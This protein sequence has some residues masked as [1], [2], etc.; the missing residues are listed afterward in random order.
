MSLNVF[1][2][3]NYPKQYGYFIGLK[4]NLILPFK[5]IF[6]FL[7]FDIFF[8]SKDQDKWVVREIF[9]NKKNGFFVDLAAT[10][11]FHQNN[12]YFLEK[13]LNWRGVCI[14]PNKNFFKKLIKLRNVK[15][16]C[17]IVS[18]KIENVNYLNNGGVGGIIGDKFDN[19]NKKRKDLIQ[20]ALKNNRVENRQSKTLYEILKKAKAPKVIDYLS[21][22][23]EG[24]ELEVLKNFPFKKYKFLS[25]TIER[26]P[27]QLNKILFKNGYVFV[28]N[29]KVD[30]FYVHE[31]LKK[32]L[33]IKFEKFYQIG[34]KK[35]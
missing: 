34:E 1:L 16:F 12:T 30:G 31:S 27:K 7:G 8:G 6:F 22:D 14:E 21:L 2:Y 11:G 17:E 19:N 28:K 23:V 3:S 13:K 15:C 35:W 4:D 18:S 20:K 24:A 33:N 5:K 32:K 10:N 25:M 26:P 29:Y 9:K